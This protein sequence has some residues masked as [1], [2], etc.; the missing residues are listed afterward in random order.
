MPF[1]YLSKFES[2]GFWP[3]K[4]KKPTT[5]YLVPDGQDIEE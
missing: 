1:I 2:L 4:D 5:N 3:N